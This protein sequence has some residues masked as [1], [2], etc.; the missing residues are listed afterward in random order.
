M[1]IYDKIY[2]PNLT[3]DYA[4]TTEPIKLFSANTNNSV[5]IQKMRC[6]AEV[7]KKVRKEIRD[8][9]K[10]G[11]K[12]LDACN[13][14]EESVVKIF[15]K[16][17]K[18]AGR[19]FPTGFSV[20]NI[21]AH[22]S[23]QPNDQRV[24][25]KDDVVKIDFG[26]HVDGYIIDSA[27]THTFNPKYK[28]LIDATKEAT[29]TGI[30]MAGPDAYIPDISKAIYETIE[31]YEIEL[32]GKKM[33]IHAVSGLGGHNILQNTIHGGKIIL[34]KPE[35]PAEYLN[36]EVKCRMKADEIYAIE[37]F[38]S[39]GTGKITHSNVPISHYSLNNLDYK[40][41]FTF[42]VTKIVYNW[43]KTRRGKLPFCT[44][45]IYD[46]LKDKVGEKYKAALNELIKRNLVTAYPAIE[47]K[48]G[49][50]TSQLEHTIYL[51]EKGKEIL[52]ASDDY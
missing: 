2:T 8:K 5:N 36:D 25:K 20:N 9:L 16:D 45:W 3:F 41:D 32:N 40:G 34:S 49:T 10:P 48:E 42:G 19:G 26:T 51:H 28:N 12:Y 46:D 44:R 43:I 35:Y 38:A 39:T 24:L 11:M 15:G 13:F 18:T 50:Y 27:F 6:A 31:S 7:H 17:D 33:E 4:K 21:A 47:D 14:V 52:S 23:A 22:D 29:W 37:T 1:S 30:K